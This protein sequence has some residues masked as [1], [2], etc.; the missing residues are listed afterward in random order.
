MSGFKNTSSQISAAYTSDGRYVVCP[1]EDSH[2]YLWRA[3]R[4]PP[5]AAA[6]GSI[7][8][9]GMKPKT[10]CTIRSFENFTAGRLRRRAVAAGPSGAGGDGSTSGSSPSR[11]QGGVSCT[12]DV[13]SMPAKSGELGSSG[14]PLTHSGQLGSPAPGGGK[15]GADGNAWGLVVVTASLQGE[16]RVYQ[17]FGM[18]FR[19][20]GQGNLFY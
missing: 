18:P 10:W 7:G 15:G 6:I 19:I 3:A 11:R 5:A 20:R 8:G 14:T 13:C 2:V 4:A 16:I 17:N 12:D 1:S 9:I